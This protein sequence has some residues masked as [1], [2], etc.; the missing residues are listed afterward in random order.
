MKRCRLHTSKEEWRII[1]GYPAYEV[2]NRGRVRSIP[3]Q[4]RYFSNQW[5]RW[6]VRWAPGH[7]RKPHV[8]D[9]RGVVDVDLH[10][11]FVAIHRL[12]LLAF[13]GP[14]PDGKQACH[15]PDNSPS[16]NCIENLRWGTPVENCEDRDIHGNTRRGS[17][18][19]TSKLSASQVQAVRQFFNRPIPKGQQRRKGVSALAN[20][21]GVS[22]TALYL[23]VHRKNWKHLR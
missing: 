20:E 9:D 19:N 7:V 5:R 11:R 12:V 8:V 1:P 3:R 6:V 13:S 4:I 10:G 22:T 2:S 18:V 17:A 15:F 23:I 14:C 21:L 16:H